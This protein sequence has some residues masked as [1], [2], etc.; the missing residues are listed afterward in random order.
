M[1]DQ[2]VGSGPTIQDYLDQNDTYQNNK[3][4]S[5]GYGRDDIW[6]QQPEQKVCFVKPGAEYYDQYGR[7]LGQGRPEVYGCRS[8][9]PYDSLTPNLSPVPHPSPLFPRR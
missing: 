3:W 6:R 5:R 2:S 4:G 7:Y 1:T 8:V 9:E